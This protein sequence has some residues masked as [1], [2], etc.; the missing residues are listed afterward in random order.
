MV[1]FNPISLNADLNISTNDCVNTINKMLAE[2]DFARTFF[3]LYMQVKIDFPEPANPLIQTFCGLCPHCQ[4]NTLLS[5]KFILC[6]L[7]KP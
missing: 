2:G 1:T 5:I 6:L 4:E 3:W 7:S